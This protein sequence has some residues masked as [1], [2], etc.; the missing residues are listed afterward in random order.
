MDNFINLLHLSIFLHSKITMAGDVVPYYT[1]T[2]LVPTLKLPCCCFEVAPM[3]PLS[4]YA[5]TP[6][7]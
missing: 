6:T 5:G 2:A 7:E 3:L 1:V 4:T